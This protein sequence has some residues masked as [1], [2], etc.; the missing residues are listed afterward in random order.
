MFF[1]GKFPHNSE[2]SIDQ[3][4]SR[5]PYCVGS[6]VYTR[7]CLRTNGFAPQ[8]ITIRGVFVSLYSLFRLENIAKSHRFGVSYDVNSAPHKSRY[9]ALDA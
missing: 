4:S 8:T 5:Y 9:A 2:T 7:L 6:G 1:P 3:V